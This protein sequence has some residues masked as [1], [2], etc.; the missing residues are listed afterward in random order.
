MV[1][2]SP[3]GQVKGSG[4]K[5]ER[6]GHPR[7]RVNM[8]LRYRCV[9]ETQTPLESLF[10]KGRVLDI[11]EGG[12]L[13]EVDRALDLGQMIEVYATK[14]ESSSGVYG[15]VVAVRVVRAID[16][17]EVGMKFTLRERI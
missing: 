3:P 17:Y 10:S 11:S 7:F 15:L 6:R 1:I 13:A 8:R 4:R 5:R 14:E 16:L 12:L 2:G 9:D